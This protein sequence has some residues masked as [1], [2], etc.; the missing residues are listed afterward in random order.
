MNQ[1]KSSAELKTMAKNK[2]TGKYGTAILVIFLAEAISMFASNILSFLIPA[3]AAGFLL[4]LLVSL[5]VSVITGVFNAGI[6]LFFLNAACDRPYALTDLFY[7]FREQP[8]KCLAVS[9]V[10][11]LVNFVCLT[12]Y[13]V[14]SSFYLQ[15]LSPQWMMASMLTMAVGLV[16]Y[17]P[18]SLALSQSFYLILDYP[19]LTASE[20]LKMSLRVMKGHKGRLFY[21]EVS[22]LPL[23]FLCVL[24]CCIGFLWA[25]SY[26]H[27]WKIPKAPVHDLF[28]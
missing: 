19:D 28:V 12:P 9:A 3:N 4:S 25:V 5:A 8:N 17:V 1:Y 26:T 15:T 20:T 16:I 6:A 2:L 10:L 18:L 27:L 22:F 21:I 14:M 24:T 11:A 13:Q 7:G 23:M